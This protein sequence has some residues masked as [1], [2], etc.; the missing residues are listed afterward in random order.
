[1]LKNRDHIETFSLIVNG[2]SVPALPVAL[3]IAR[4]VDRTVGDL[5]GDIVDEELD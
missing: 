4:V 2:K 3:R 5:W 1:L